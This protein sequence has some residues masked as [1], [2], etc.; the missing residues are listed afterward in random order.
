MRWPDYR[1]GRPQRPTWSQ[2]WVL[3]AV[4]VGLFGYWP[5]QVPVQPPV[6]TFLPS[7][8]G[9]PWHGLD[10]PLPL[11]PVNLAV[12]QSL[13]LFNHTLVSGNFRAGNGG[14]PLAIVYDGGRGVLFVGSPGVLSVVNDTSNVVV[15]GI[16]V[17]SGAGALAYDSG[18]GEI[19]VADSNLNT[20]T[21]LSDLTY[22]VLATVH[23]GSSPDALVYDSAKGEV[24]VAN[25][26]S[27]NVSIISD[28]TNSVVASVPV[29][30]FSR[31][32]AYDFATGEVFVANS[33][34]ANV[35]VVS[36]ANNTV[37][38][39][40]AVDPL[41]VS[42][43]YDRGKG[44]VVVAH[45]NSGAG[46]IGNLSVISDAT[47]A[48]TRVVNLSTPGDVVYDP[49]Q[50]EIF[51]ANAGS[52][53]MTILND[54]SNQVVASVPV[55]NQPYGVA[56]DPARGEVLATNYGSANVS[57]ISDVTNQVVATIRVGAQPAGMVYDSLTREIFVAD[58][59]AN[60]VSVISDSNR[61]V[62]ATVP[63]GHQ[64]DG[65]AYDSGK[66]QIFVANGFRD[67]PET[68]TVS[69][70]SDLTNQVVATVSVGYWPAA[71]AYD[72]AKGEVLVANWY[73]DTV[74][75]ISDTTDAVV[76]TVP[77][78]Q[79][80]Y[81]V[82]YDSGRG[83]IFVA[84]SL[85]NNLSV[86]SDSSNRIVATL[87]FSDSAPASPRD[88][89]Y[90][91]GKGEIFVGSFGGDN[92]TVISDSN[93]SIVATIPVSGSPRGFAY[94]RGNGEIV[95]TLE[96]DHGIGVINDTSNRVVAAVQVGDSPLGVSYD[97][98][99]RDLFVGNSGQGTLSI[100]VCQGGACLG[101]AISAFTASPPTITVGGST[102]L[103]VGLSSSGAGQ[104]NFTF[105]GLPPGCVTLDVPSLSCSPDSAGVFLVRVYANDSDGNDVSATVLL[106]VDPVTLFNVTFVEVGLPAGTNWSVDLNGTSTRSASPTHTLGVPNGTY[107]FAVPAV[108]G[109]VPTPDS[110]LVVVSGLPLT[111]RVAW[112]PKQ[113]MVTFV[114]SGLAGGTTWSVSLQGTTVTTSG[115]TVNFTAA[116]GTYAYSVPGLSGYRT[117]TWSGTVRVSGE[118]ESVSVAWTRVTYSVSFTERGLPDGSPWN[119][120]L[121]AGAQYINWTLSGAS[122]SWELANGTYQYSIGAPAAYSATPASGRITVAGGGKSVS[123]TFAV[124]EGYVKGSLAPES[125]SLSIGSIRV[126]LTGGKFN[127]TENPGIFSVQV[128]ESG[129]RAYS[130]D[131]LVLPG[132]VAW[133]NITLIPNAS[134]SE[135][136][137]L[138]LNPY[139][140]IGIVVIGVAALVACGVLLWKRHRSTG[141][142]R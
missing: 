102:T 57:A 73:S 129:Y 111:I 96:G 86:I 83:E 19:F 68:G 15:V 26:L 38:A 44:E 27:N 33:A 128:A 105:T 54:T 134:S 67:V 12:I 25:A 37:V 3:L 71:I 94:E 107:L 31:A 41:P 9:G 21:I 61:N 64:P 89:A 106:S 88:L 82:A 124:E 28:M 109:Y 58:R 70:I 43:A 60:S 79:G 112:A 49:V 24:F 74:S 116:N 72:G 40:I 91:Y 110:G 78:G 135:F 120:Q 81:G 46:A 17:S 119:V 117:P 138:G 23:V 11:A 5:I 125:A 90:D 30:G 93:N 137:L 63:V 127:L 131:V 48:V 104:L 87:P 53:A 16:P 55:G 34:T 99:T 69:V 13:V 8:S 45:N 4:G 66:N 98:R 50:G 62:V 1:R 7:A 51:V 77:V 2:M 136:Q 32:E 123:V 118:N 42:L 101:P 65:V 35:S 126:H 139:G 130:A 132:Q 103:M 20:V 22:A 122:T 6:A 76:A 52:G 10:H 108:A 100:V 142:I 85:S 97:D 18:K 59:L 39:T 113:F 14:S 114:E 75:V 140:S 115:S 80:P 95:M 84:N 36:D 29:G 56:Y 141:K 92:L 133:L 47:N 121:S